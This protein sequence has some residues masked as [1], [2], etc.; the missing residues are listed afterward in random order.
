MLHR[1]ASSVGAKR[2]LQQQGN[3]SIA[4]SFNRRLLLYAFVTMSEKYTTWHNCDGGC[5][6]VCHMALTP[7]IPPQASA[8]PHG[9]YDYEYQSLISKHLFPYLHFCVT[10][11][12]FRV[13]TGPHKKVSPPAFPMRA[14]AK[15]VPE[16]DPKLKPFSL[17]PAFR[18]RPFSTRTASTS[19][20]FS[21]SSAVTSSRHGYVVV[22]MVIRSFITRG[23]NVFY[24]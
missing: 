19:K 11:S 4:F 21:C 17:T 9:S 16:P 15:S 7:S 18:G 13:R 3:W 10:T 8:L 1:I 24:L 22:V 14:I 5:L 2:R 23:K 20:R 6:Q 12:L